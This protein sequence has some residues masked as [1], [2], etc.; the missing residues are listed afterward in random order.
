MDT[1]KIVGAGLLLIATC[2]GLGSCVYDWSTSTPQAVNVTI[3]D[4]SHT[5]GYYST[6][7]STD[8]K[9][10]M[11]C[12]NTWNPPSWYIT[13]EETFDRFSTS[14]SSGTYENLKVGDKK[15]LNY[16]LGGYWGIRYNEKFLLVTPSA[17]SNNN[18]WK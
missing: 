4:K 10:H 6:H 16:N 17:E 18:L 15:I 14:V 1:L 2:A 8:D 9:G 11:S 3:I 7:C 12:S 5:P 13:Y